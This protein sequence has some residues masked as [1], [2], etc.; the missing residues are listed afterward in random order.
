M[1]TLCF[2][3][4]L[5]YLSLSGISFSQ[6]QSSSNDQCVQCRTVLQDAE[7]RIYPEHAQVTI[8]LREISEDNYD[9][10]ITFYDPY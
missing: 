10:M 3:F 8:A 5:V 7:K 1:K 9:V 2:T 4:L 6:V